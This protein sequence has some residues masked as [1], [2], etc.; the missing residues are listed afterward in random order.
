MSSFGLDDKKDTFEK[1]SVTSTQLESYGREI[2][3]VAS[4]DRVTST[5]L[6]S[7]GREIGK[8]DS[9]GRGTSAQLESYGREIG[10]ASR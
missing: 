7:Y 3:K 5:Q 6:E 10:K 8:V 2:G 9:F 1:A 4:F